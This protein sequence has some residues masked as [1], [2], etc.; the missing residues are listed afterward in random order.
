[1]DGPVLTAKR[2]VVST[3]LV[4]L[5]TIA[6][7]LLSGSAP[8]RILRAST[9]D[10]HAEAASP[11]PARG[12]TVGYDRTYKTDLVE[13][14]GE[15]PELIVLGGS[16]AQRFEPSLLRRLT[17]LSAFNYALQN[18]RPE[19]AYA[20][21]RRL[22]VRT[23]DVRVR[24]IYA[25]QCTTFS[26]VAMHPGLLYDPRLAAAFP[27]ALVARQKAA[28]GTV[29]AHS[30]LSCN[31]FSA[32]GCLL[33]N[34]YDEREQEGHTLGES[35]RSYLSSLL[36]RAASTAPVEQSRARHYFCKLLALQNAH[37]VTPLLVLMPYQPEAL[38]AFREV[39]WQ[40]KLERLKAYLARL[41]HGYDFRVLDCT[42]IATFGGSADAFY[43][44]AHVKTE[45][46]RRILRYAVRAAP[47]CFH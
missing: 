46:A 6:G 34:T 47:A 27:R 10:A 45:N 30:L 31:T 41:H 14:L 8:A 25:I 32:R 7:A 12:R 20:V 40:T 4:V 24:C 26:N 18:C 42:E 29:H 16:R 11:R 22:Y 38:R 21:T 39:G 15:S 37:G 43:D 5:A 36:P 19:D 13:R 35:L 44:G 2:L 3:G 1:V 33:W 28:L 23:P 9:L 17:G